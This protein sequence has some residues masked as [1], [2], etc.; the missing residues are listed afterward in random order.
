MTAVGSDIKYRRNRELR[1]EIV[2][3]AGGEPAGHF[4]TPS[5]GIPKRHFLEIAR[6]LQPVDD[7]TDLDDVTLAELYELVCEWVGTEYQ[8][9]AGCQ[10]SLRRH[11]LK[12]IY[13]S[14]SEI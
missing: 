14:L 4:D 3:A 13:R 9:T 7:E 5:R 6:A 10:W 12:A 1:E 11:H 2:R 8:G